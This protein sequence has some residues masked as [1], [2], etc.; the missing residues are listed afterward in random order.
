MSLLLD[1][2][3]KCTYMVK[4]PVDDGYGGFNTTWVEGVNFDA[5]IVLDISI[6]A[7]SA[8]K[9][10]VKDVYTVT[11]VKGINLQF[12]D[13][14]RR[15]EDGKYFRVTS[16]GDDKKTPASASLNMRQVK[17]EEYELEN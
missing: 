2:M 16:N 13:V 10:G 9:A 1:N 4:T 12:Y 3:T 14:F 5:A 7:R 11:T 6:Q 8:E 15:E 17:A